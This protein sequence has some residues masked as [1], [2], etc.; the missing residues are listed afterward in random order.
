[1]TALGRVSRASAV[2]TAIRNCTNNAFSNAQFL[3]AST[4]G[5]ATITNNTDAER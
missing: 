1:M 3:D 2:Q 5:S 4:A